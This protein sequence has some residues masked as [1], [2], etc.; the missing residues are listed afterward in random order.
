MQ[1]HALLPLLAATLATAATDEPCV[2]SGGRAGVCLSTSSCSSAGGITIDGA[3]PADPAGIKCCSKATCANGSAGNCR[4]QSDC[5]GTSVSGLCPGPAQMKCCS[6]SA[7]GFGGYSAPSVP[8][9]GSCKAN[10]V[11]GAKK[12][13]AAFPGRVRE[14]GCVRACTCGASGASDHCCGMAIDFMCSDA[15]GVSFKLAVF[16]F[17]QVTLFLNFVS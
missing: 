9:I 13:I 8:A 17:F 10:A 14:I 12:V 15:G 2:G 7:T 16:F 11:N 3:C 5:A 1:L 6:S 4:W